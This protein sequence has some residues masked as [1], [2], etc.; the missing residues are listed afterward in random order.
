MVS[1]DTP[2]HLLNLQNGNVLQVTLNDSLTV[3]EKFELWY[4]LDGSNPKQL[5]L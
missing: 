3:I 4:Y 5:R 2:E 1:E